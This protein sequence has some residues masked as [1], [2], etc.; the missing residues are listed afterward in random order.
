MKADKH[1]PAGVSI[2]A[3]TAAGP[4]VLWEIATVMALAWGGQPTGE[5]IDKRA[6][7]L[8]ADL[9]SLD[10]QAAAMFVARRGDCIVGF[11]RVMRDKAAD[12]SQWLLFAIAVHPDHARQGIGTARGAGGDR[13]CQAAGRPVHPLRDARR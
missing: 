11:G 8:T 7:R 6:K 4:N 3:L 5:E 10:P 12:A 13:V 2:E 9:L 1:I